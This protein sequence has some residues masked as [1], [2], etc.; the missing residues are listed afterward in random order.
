M[1]SF[2]TVGRLLSTLEVEEPPAAEAS[3]LLVLVSASKLV[4]T[5]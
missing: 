1:L 5:A 4:D 3:E 2:T